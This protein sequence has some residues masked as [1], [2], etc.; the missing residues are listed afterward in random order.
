MSKSI[1]AKQFEKEHINI[2]E[3]DVPRCV[4]VAGDSPCTASQTG[5]AKC[6]NTR[7]TCNDLANYNEIISIQTGMS[8]NAST[9]TFN[10][11]S[12]NFLTD[13][14]KV[15]QIITTSLFNNESNNFQFEIKSVSS[16]LLV[17]T[18]NDG[19]V[20]ESTGTRKITTPNLYTYKFCSARSPHPFKMNNIIPCLSDVNIAPASIDAKGGIGA[21]T[22]VSVQMDDLP[23]SDRNGIDPYLSERTYNAFDV[24]LFFVKWRTRN[25]NY[26]NY[27]ARVLSGYIVDNTYVK[28]NFE[29][30]Y[31]VLSTMTATNGSAGFT[32]KD[33][34][35]LISNKKALAPM[36]SNGVLSSDITN[37]AT[38]LNLQPSGIGDDEYPASGI[39][40]IKSEVAR[41]TR[42]G[43]ALTLARGQ[44]NTLAT[45]HKSGDTAQICLNYDGTRSVDLVQA[46]LLIKYSGLPS[47]TIPRGIWKEEAGDFLI[48]NPN[49]LITDP[50]LVDSL[51]SQLCEQ[52]PH[53]LFWNDRSR[54][55]EFVALKAPPNSATNS[56]TFSKNLLE[57]SVSDQPSMQLSTIFVMYG[58]FDPTK[59]VDEKDNYQITT[60]RV[61]VDAIARYNSNNSIVIYAPWISAGNGAAAR[62]ISTLKGRR[63]GIVPR[64]IAFALEDK[65][66]LTWLGDVKSILHPDISDQNGNPIATNFEITQ[67]SEGDT[68]TYQALEF[69]YDEALAQDDAIGV[70]V[71]D[72]PIDERNINLRDKYNAIYGTPTSSTVAKFI[73]YSG[74]VI[75]S[76]SVSVAS[77]VTG[78]WPAGASV[79]LQLNS[80]SAVVGFAGSGSSAGNLNGTNGFD[81]ISLA[82]DL[83]I[84]N[85]GTIGGGAGGGGSRNQAGYIAAGGGGAGDISGNAG[86]SDT[87]GQGT[88]TSVQSAQNGT[89]E[90]GGSG[91]RINYNSAGEPFILIGGA[92]G[93]LGQNGADGQ[94]DGIG[95]NGGLAGKAVDLNGNILTQPVSGD[96]FGTVS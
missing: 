75:G 33:P 81:A 7:A 83:T 4:N 40:K 69:N 47:I 6:Y 29:V 64:Q 92:G 19:L 90:A 43:D 65:D 86:T 68:F 85:D 18:S 63:F 14:F 50:T 17:V 27:Q 28:S 76:T 22:S 88:L 70:G 5:D 87:T 9:S 78:N 24:G 91:A 45:E 20:N 30:R 74:V 46:E 73:V 16:T 31:Y 34:L 32:F 21:R 71:V 57:L 80:G 82:Y 61:N 59:K 60:S 48:S 13:G 53:K 38:S 77:L 44:F 54:R 52:W 2:V 84:V 1:L 8:L 72:L 95:S 23:S 79:T 58:Q 10:R 42:S 41:F 96:I 51:V 89:P 67:A 15:G 56:L 66:S 93:S 37:N 49:R 11:I 36:P 55:V 62:R 39:I 3:I 94:G 26:E 35:Q 12:G 25:A